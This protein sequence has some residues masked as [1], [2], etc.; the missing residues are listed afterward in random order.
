MFVMIGISIVG[1][2]IL[3]T[4]IMGI[5]IVRPTEVRLVERLGKYKETL[6]Q[7]FHVVIPYVDNVISVNMTEEMDD[8]APQTVITKDKLNVIIDAVVYYKIND[9]YK[10]IYNVNDYFSQLI[11]LART[12]LR[13][14]I[15]QMTLSEANESRSTINNKIEEILDMETK[16]YGVDVLMVEIQKIEP[17][18]DV[19]EAMNNVVKA[20][21][22][23]IAA[24]ETALALETQAD[25]QRMAQIKIA[26]G[27]RDAAILRAEGK[28][29]AQIMEAEGQAKSIELVN[30]A[31]D[32]FF[33]GN[34]Q[35]LK[36]LEVTQSTLA[37]N[38]KM[39]VPA[40]SNLI[41]ILGDLMGSNNNQKRDQEKG[42]R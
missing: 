11:S 15:G 33:K 28:M 41:N 35:E 40:N 36:R 32:K 25:G 31:A 3:V 30:G 19:I 23:K 2:F 37:S 18:H 17:P 22:S 39:I 8:V 14:V 9:A 12:T 4:V 16:A 29:K 13:S 6:G 7:G 34:A 26:T 42:G 5:Q 38:L 21:Q 20:E 24:K 27:D 10:S 1:I